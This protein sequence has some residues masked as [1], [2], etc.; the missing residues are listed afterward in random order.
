MTN[1]PER[2]PIDQMVDLFV[3]APLGMV[4]EYQDVLPK[5]IKRGK[6]QVQIARF[7]GTMAAKQ[8]QKK[9]EGRLDDVFDAA[10]SSVVQGI[11]DV[12]TRVGLAPDP[13]AMR[14]PEPPIQEASDVA[15]DRPLPIAGYADL[16]AKQIVA[17]L[18]DLTAE[19]RT[20][21]ETYERANR[22][23]KTVLAKLSS[24]GQER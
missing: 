17:L 9:V 20:R 14:S 2:R 22:A 10:S 12:G 1:K 18:P 15:D 7:L 8:G 19:Q 3:Y 16:T 6:S 24:L 4:Y 23:R 5:L 11:T 13:A 21:V